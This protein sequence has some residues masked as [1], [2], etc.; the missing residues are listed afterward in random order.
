MG[1]GMVQD[2]YSFYV[3]SAT[4][5]NVC[6]G[7]DMLNYTTISTEDFHQAMRLM[8]Y[9]TTCWSQPVTW[10]DAPEPSQSKSKH[11]EVAEDD[12]SVSDEM[13]KYIKQMELEA[14]ER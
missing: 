3:S 11:R 4:T 1:I 10:N 13:K 5:T 2:P 8:P 9:R 14:G 6:S 12:L 7:Y